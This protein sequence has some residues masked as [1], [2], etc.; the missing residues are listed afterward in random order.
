MGALRFKL[1]EIVSIVIYGPV[2]QPRM[3]IFNTTKWKYL[4]SLSVRVGELGVGHL[5]EEGVRRV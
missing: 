2:S 4:S 1:Q 5:L 3:R